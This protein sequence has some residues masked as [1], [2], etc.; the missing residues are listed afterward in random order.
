PPHVRVVLSLA[1]AGSVVAAV[2]SLF[3]RD[4]VFTVPILRDLALGHALPIGVLAVGYV[5]AW[6]FACAAVR[7]APT[8][9]LRRRARWMLVAFGL[10]W[11]AFAGILVYGILVFEIV[12]F[13][14]ATAHVLAR[15]RRHRGERRVPPD[16]GAARS[17]RDVPRARARRG[18]RHRARGAQSSHGVLP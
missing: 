8:P 6:V 2:G 5:T 17:G 14:R 15:Q 11:L 9:L 18:R 13:Q 4:F 10:R 1:A 16:A 12:E 3:L 7:H